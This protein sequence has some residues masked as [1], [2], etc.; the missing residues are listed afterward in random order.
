MLKNPVFFAVC[1]ALAITNLS[2]TIAQ[3]EVKPKVPT[4]QINPYAAQYIPAAKSTSKV[5]PAS[6][7][8]ANHSKKPFSESSSYTKAQVSTKSVPAST[9]HAALA[10]APSIP[11]QSAI[12]RTPAVT[13]APAVSYAPAVTAQPICTSRS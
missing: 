6:T 9:A 4:W 2:A 10:P 8:S 7:D 13:Y 11:N 12:E 1:A 5:Q 3:T